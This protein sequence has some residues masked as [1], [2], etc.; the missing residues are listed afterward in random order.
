MFQWYANKL[1]IY[2]FIGVEFFILEFPEALFTFACAIAIDECL[3]L[4]MMYW[5]VSLP[6]FQTPLGTGLALAISHAS[7]FLQPP[8][9][10]SIVIE[11]MHSGDLSIS[12]FECKYFLNIF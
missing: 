2:N 3:I 8:P 11:R 1:I 4:C 9:H 12:S 7:H 5:L 6:F 10:Q